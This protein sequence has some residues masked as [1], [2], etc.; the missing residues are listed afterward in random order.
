MS[1]SSPEEA[2]VKNKTQKPKKTKIKVSK[3]D[4][5]A[6]KG[7]AKAHSLADPLNS[8]RAGEVAAAILH[9]A[10]EKLT[11]GE[12][13]AD[14]EKRILDP[15]FK[16]GLVAKLSNASPLEIVGGRTMESSGGLTVYADGFKIWEGWS[17]KKVGSSGTYFARKRSQSIRDNPNA[18]H[19]IKDAVAHIVGIYT[20]Q[21]S[22]DD[23]HCRKPFTWYS[24]LS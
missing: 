8:M 14:L 7:L 3:E 17:D 12:I 9:L 1:N 19:R 24:G 10:L 4:W 20:R 15:L 6:I 22:S 5:K 13:P 2:T 21:I 18:Y 16:A 23:R 11:P